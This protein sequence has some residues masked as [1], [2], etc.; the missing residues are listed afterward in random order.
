MDEEAAWDDFCR[1]TAT[2]L[3]RGHGVWVVEPKAGGEVLGFVLIGCEPGDR[4]PELGF[5]FRAVGE[6]QGYASEAARLAKTHAFVTLGLSGLV[7]YVAEGNERSTR[8]AERLGGERDLAAE[9]ELGEG[10]RVYRY[11]PG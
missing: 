9:A 11:R 7:S 3:L 4:E 1:M 5:L 8:L 2:W 10:D 6:G